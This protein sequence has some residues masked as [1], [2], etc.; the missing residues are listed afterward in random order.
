M[1]ID[2]RLERRERPRVAAALAELR[3]QIAGDFRAGVVEWRPRKAPGT[4]TLRVKLPLD[5]KPQVLAEAMGRLIRLTL[6]PLNKALHQEQ[7]LAKVASPAGSP[8]SPN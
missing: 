7:D 4:G 2:I 6:D 5:S 1:G 8:V 3:D